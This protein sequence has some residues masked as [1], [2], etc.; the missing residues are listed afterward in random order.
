[1]NQIPDGFTIW[2][3]KTIESGIFTDKPAMWFKIWFYLVSRVLYAD[4]EKL[5]R[6]QRYLKYDWIR[7]A[8][9][10]TRAQI[11]HVLRWLRDRE[12]LATQKATHGMVVTIL[13][14]DKYQTICN[15]KSDTV[16][17]TEATQKRHRSDNILKK[18]KNDKKETNT[19]S[20]LARQVL[21]YLNEKASKHYRNIGEIEARL[22]DGGTVAQC[23]QIIDTKLKDPHFQ[24][25]P[26]Y[27][28]PVT[29]FRRSHWDNYLNEDPND[30]EVKDDDWKGRFLRSDK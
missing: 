19:Y 29:L 12:M 22:R 25:H 16:G 27:Y 15:Y 5:K 28:N 13:N 10:A 18:V 21:S 30:Y 11:D 9:G 23:K 2:A 20:V 7:E 26:K 8:T 14:Y 4:S 17:D 6:G 24:E 1:M 3:R